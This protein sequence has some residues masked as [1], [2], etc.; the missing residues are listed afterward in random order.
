[1]AR[2]CPKCQGSMVEGVVVDNSYG[3]RGVSSW[4]EGTPVKS[5]WVGLKL[6]GKKPIDIATFRCTRC[7]YLESFARP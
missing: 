4:L 2:E 3:T 1:M 6:G 7:F 5:I